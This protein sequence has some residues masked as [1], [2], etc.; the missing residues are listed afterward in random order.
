M[1]TLWQDYDENCVSMQGKWFGTLSFAGHIVSVVGPFDT[2]A[3]AAEA[4][5]EATDAA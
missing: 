2:E 3:L 5:S 4:L 1:I